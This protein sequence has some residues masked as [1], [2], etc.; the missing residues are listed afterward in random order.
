MSD[1]VRVSNTPIDRLTGLCA[2]M[3]EVLEEPGNED[4]KAIVFLQDGEH[5]GIQTEGYDNQM[6]AMVDLFVHLRAM[7]RSVG[8]DV[9]IIGLNSA[10]PEADPQEVL[11]AIRDEQQRRYGLP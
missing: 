1:D 2:R 6:D 3:T 4:V 10:F 7:L 9:T 5:G 8:K 11:D